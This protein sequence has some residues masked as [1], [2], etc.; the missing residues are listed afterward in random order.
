M[1]WLSQTLTQSLKY[2]SNRL[3]NNKQSCSFI[4]DFSKRQNKAKRKQETQ[5]TTLNLQFSNIYCTS[6]QMTSHTSL[7]LYDTVHRVSWKG[8]VWMQWS[9]YNMARQVTCLFSK[10][11]QQNVHTRQLSPSLSLGLLVF[12][13]STT[14]DSFLVLHTHTQKGQTTPPLPRTFSYRG[15]TEKRWAMG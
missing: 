14:Q 10:R 1:R 4:S 5:T 3:N 7:I 6:L 8:F 15:T 11:N 13:K 12:H 9:A 2:T